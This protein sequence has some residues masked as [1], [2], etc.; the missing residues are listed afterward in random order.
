M[1][2]VSGI[3]CS[4]LIAKE[5]PHNVI[6][7]DKGMTC[8]IIPRKYTEKQIGM[9]TSW[10]DISG[11]TTIYDEGLLNN[12]KQNG[13]EVILKIFKEELCL[14]NEAFKMISEELV[15]MFTEKFKLN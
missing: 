2:F 1:A 11:L 14:E 9:T 5:Y 6:F 3:I 4:L 10:L 7:S 12:V 13:I 15:G 8:F